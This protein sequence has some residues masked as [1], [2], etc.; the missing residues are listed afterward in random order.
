MV[1]G[2]YDEGKPVG[3]VVASPGQQPDAHWVAPGHQTVAIVL[4]LV[5]PVGPGRRLV[6]GLGRHGSMKPALVRKGIF[7]LARIIHD[8]MS[9]GR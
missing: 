2:L 4:D 1:H 7:Q 6:G 9:L 5:N 3:P 8:G